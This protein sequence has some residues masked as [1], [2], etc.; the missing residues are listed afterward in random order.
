MI[1]SLMFFMIAHL[2]GATMGTEQQEVDAIIDKKLSDYIDHTPGAK[3][4]SANKGS[5]AKAE[6]QGDS[7]D[8]I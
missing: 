7:L 1:I 6:N 2:E 8:S 5:G 4:S 3:N